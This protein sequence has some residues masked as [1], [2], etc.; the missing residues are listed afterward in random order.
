[1]FQ[2]T[3]KRTLPASTKS[4]HRPHL[5]RRKCPN[6]R[7]P[8]IRAH[9][10][11]HL[12]PPRRRRRK[13][14]LDQSPECDPDLRHHLLRKRALD[15]PQDHSAP[16]EILMQPRRRR[17]M[18]PLDSYRLRLPLGRH[19]WVPSRLSTTEQAIMDIL[20][21]SQLHNSNHRAKQTHGLA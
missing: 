7:A 15:S 8:T 1:M 6:I 21:N 4:Q 10:G 3:H 19:H 14:V 11:E 2:D 18:S 12:G 20:H 13:Q 17:V 9:T 16:M 5:L